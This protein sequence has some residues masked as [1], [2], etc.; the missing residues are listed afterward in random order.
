[1]QGIELAR[2]WYDAA[3]KPMLEQEFAPYV[4]RI[5]CGISGRGSECFG[6]D[7]ELSRDHDFCT[8]FSLWIT[9]ED[10]RIF[11]FKLERAYARLLKECPPELPAALRE[12]RLGAPEYGVCTISTFFRRRIGLPGAP[13]TWQQWLYTPE[14]ALAEA[15]NGEVFRDDYGIFSAI[16]QKIATGMPEDVRIKKLAARTL[17][18]AQNGQYNFARALKRN[19]RGAAAL[20]LHDFVS[21]AVPAVFLL[22]FRFAPYRK[23]QFRAMRQ[24]PLLGS[25]ADTLEFLIDSNGSDE[26]KQ[27]LIEDT[28]AAISRELNRQGLS[29]LD[30]CELENHAF[31]LMKQIRSR[32]IRSL[33]IL[34]G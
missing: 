24:L 20:A 3:G 5:A 28:A 16:R 18:M 15:V 31:E 21:A 1:M 14:Y 34:E 23:W 33:H 29:T 19:E 26:L 2:Q 11:G 12:S 9:D 30:G 8:G 4:N 13:E 27:E 32:E 10:E 25:L 17:N 6:F 7:D 22:N